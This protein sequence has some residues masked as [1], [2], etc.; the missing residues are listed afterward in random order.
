MREER[1]AVFHLLQTDRG[2]FAP[3]LVDVAHLLGFVPEGGAP[4]LNM[5]SRADDHDVAL[6]RGVVEDLLGKNNSA[7]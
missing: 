4:D 3:D 7:V 6:D 2:E 5:I 1:F